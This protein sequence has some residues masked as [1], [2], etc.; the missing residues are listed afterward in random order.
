MSPRPETRLPPLS[1]PRLAERAADL[2]R[3]PQTL[4][5]LQPDEAAQ[6]VARMGLVAWGPGMVVLREGDGGAPVQLLLLL[7]GEVE[8]S[9]SGGGPAELPIAVLGAGSVIGEMALFD[10]EPRSATCTARSHVLAAALTRG[11]LD[12]LIDQHPRTAAKLLMGLAQR[13]SERLRALGEQLQIYA[14]IGET[15]AGRLP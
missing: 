2:L 3:M 8:V 10:G 9:T 1:D 13:L 7:E 14:R 6:V 12:A 15:E 11:A 5:P 4:L